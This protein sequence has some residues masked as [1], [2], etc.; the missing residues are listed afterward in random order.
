MKEKKIEVDKEF[1][2][3]ILQIQKE[4]RE[5]IE[6]IKQQTVQSHSSKVASLLGDESFQCGEISFLTKPRELY[7]S[8]ELVE[9]QNNVMNFR[10]EL[11]ALMRRFK[12]GLVNAQILKRL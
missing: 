2:D 3:R 7:T 4:L 6:K 5:E 12:I 10:K 1:L 11:E 8:Q 9:H